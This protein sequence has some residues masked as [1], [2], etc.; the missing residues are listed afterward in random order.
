[1]I[2]EVDAPQSLAQG[3]GIPEVGSQEA[4]FIQAIRQIFDAPAVEV[5]QDG[6]RP[7]PF[8]YQPPNQVA[9][10]ETRAAGDEYLHELSARPLSL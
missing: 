10:D 5:I 1:M 3:R 9:S 4:D 6:D 7:N 8:P 2:D